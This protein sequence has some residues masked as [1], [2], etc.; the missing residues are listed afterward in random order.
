MA[1][2]IMEGLIKTDKGIVKIVGHDGATFVPHISDDNLLFWTNDKGLENPEPVKLPISKGEISIGEEEPMEPN[3]LIWIDTGNVSVKYRDPQ[4]GTFAEVQSGGST[5]DGSV[6]KHNESETA[7]ND[8][9]LLLAGLSERLNAIADSDDTTLDQLSEIV[10]YIKANKT[11]IG[12]ITTNKVNV[13]DIIDNLTTSVSNKPLSAKMGVELNRLINVASERAGKALSDAS[14]AMNRASSA[15]SM[16]SAAQAEIEKLKENGIPGGGTS[17]S[18]EE[19]HIGADEPTDGEKL[20]IDL[21]DEGDGLTAEDVKNALGYTPANAE[22][23]ADLPNNETLIGNVAKVVKAEVPLVKTAQQ[24]DFVDSVDKMTDTSKVYVMPDMSMW[25]HKTT[26]G[27]RVT[28]LTSEDFV[29][30]NVNTDG[31]LNNVTTNKIRIATASLQPLDGDLLCINCPSPYQY[32]VYY[33]TGSTES[34]YIGKTSFKSG[35]TTNI[36]TE[37]VSSGTI[38]GAKYCRIALRDST[39]TNAI[40]TD[41]MDEFMSAISVEYVSADE[42]ETVAWVDT[43]Y[44]YNQPTDYEDRIV[45]LENALEGL[46]NGAF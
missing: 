19:I 21:D 28:P 42:V 3:I 34:T 44:T 27:K 4:T 37:T 1:K 32:I 41:R 13:S 38:A 30:T 2:E 17:A 23:I 7:H 22:A 26:T 40:L 8:I 16:A 11:L 39:N 14:D 29:A 5:D 20:W 25:V 36:L 31:A 9:R 46:E 43:G 15:Q 10:A 12:S 35:G 45:A 33:Y 24:P 18:V 6:K